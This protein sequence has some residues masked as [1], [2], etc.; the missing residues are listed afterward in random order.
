V[1]DF[2]GFLPLGDRGSTNE[3]IEAL[4]RE[5]MEKIAS[6]DAEKFAEFIRRTGDTICGEAP[7]WIGMMAM[8]RPY[9]VSWPH[10]SQSAK[11]VQFQRESCV[12]YSAGV[13]PGT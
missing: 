1:S 3:R 8:T 7:I 6:C 2:I 9:S 4:D 10:Y 12:T 11:A 13:F 5:G